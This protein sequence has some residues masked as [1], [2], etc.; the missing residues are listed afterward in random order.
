MGATLGKVVSMDRSTVSF[1]T[2]TGFLVSTSWNATTGNQQ[3]YYSNDC[4]TAGSGGAY[5]NDGGTTGS[6]MLGN[7][8]VYSRTLGTWMVPSQAA[9][10]YATSAAMTTIGSW[11]NLNRDCVARTSLASGWLLKTATRSELGLPTTT[12][13]VNQF[14]LPLSVG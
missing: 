5:L 10:G 11:E 9:S 6:V 1:V 2:S 7:A 8:A 13:N 4:A 3:I 12:G 14:V